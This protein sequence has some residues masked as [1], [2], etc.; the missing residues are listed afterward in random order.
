MLISKMTVAIQNYCY[1]ESNIWDTLHSIHYTVV[2]SEIHGLASEVWLYIPSLQILS[3]Q[4]L[5]FVKK[6]NP[7]ICH[8]CVGGFMCLFFSQRDHLQAAVEDVMTRYEPVVPSKRYE[9]SS[10]VYST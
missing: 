5:P 2:I 4:N 1:A 7:G 10:T 9:V 8:L 3:L 6:I